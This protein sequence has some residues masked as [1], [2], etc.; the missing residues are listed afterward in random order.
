M[1]MGKN[2]PQSNNFLAMHEVLLKLDQFF[3]LQIK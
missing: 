3:M 1:Q 2:S